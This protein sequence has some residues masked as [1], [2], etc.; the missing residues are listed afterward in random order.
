MTDCRFGSP[1]YSIEKCSGDR[2]M[3]IRRFIAA[4]PDVTNEDISKAMNIRIQTVTPRTRELKVN[5]LVWVTGKALTSSGHVACTMSAAT[6]PHCM[7]TK[8]EAN[9]EDREFVS[10]YCYTCGERFR[11]RTGGLKT[12]AVEVIP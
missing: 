9:Q 4:N 2:C 8:L 3:K 12:T 6:C 1:Y 11:A 7:S 10:Y 5:G